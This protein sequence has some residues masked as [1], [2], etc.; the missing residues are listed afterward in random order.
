MYL[1]DPFELRPPR[2]VGDILADGMSRADGCACG[3][4]QPPDAAI[5]H[6]RGWITHYVCADCQRA[7]T[8]TW[9][10]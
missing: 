10:D 9:K 3:N 2:R 1:H 5:P 4:T 6:G 7:W 8:A